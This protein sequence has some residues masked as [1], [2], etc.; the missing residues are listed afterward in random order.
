LQLAG[1]GK[2]TSGFSLPRHGFE[3]LQTSTNQSVIQMPPPPERINTLAGML[4]RM[5][6]RARALSVSAWTR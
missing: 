4:D 3:I 5:L 6:Y 1:A 2:Q